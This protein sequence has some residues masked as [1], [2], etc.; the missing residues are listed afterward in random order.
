MPNGWMSWI[1]NH[2]GLD[3]IAQ[4]TQGDE[5][6]TEMEHPT[7]D[8]GPLVAAKQALEQDDLTHHPEDDT[9]ACRRRRGGRD[10]QRRGGAG[11]LNDL[12]SQAGHEHKGGEIEQEG[13]EARQKRHVSA[14]SVELDG[15]RRVGS[16]SKPRADRS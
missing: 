9:R 12:A 11:I 8:P 7:E 16:S 14:P 13:I 10:L 1:G 2:T 6:E 3:E 15:I 5:E 4:M